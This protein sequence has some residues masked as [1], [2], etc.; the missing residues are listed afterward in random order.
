MLGFVPHF[1]EK[2]L[3]LSCILCT[4][5][6]LL[7]KMRSSEI[8]H[9]NIQQ[10]FCKVC[11]FFSF[12]YSCNRVVINY[13][14][15]TISDYIYEQKI[16]G[17]ILI[18][19]IWSGKCPIKLGQLFKRRFCEQNFVAYFAYYLISAL[20]YIFSYECFTHEEDSL[21][22]HLAHWEE[23]NKGSSFH[24]SGK[25]LAIC[26][27]AVEEILLTSWNEG[28]AHEEVVFQWKDVC[29]IPA[30]TSCWD[31]HSLDTRTSNASLS[32]C[33]AGL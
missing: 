11:V 3:T 32:E 33:Y 7:H 20:N 9:S 28:K 25:T 13:V 2:H 22:L 16:P 23:T 21:G 19:H 8:L 6:D 5:K 10:H 15:Y 31:V 17:G 29:P 18:P 26:L 30:T 24:Q 4:Q 1:L 12:L 27:G 14:F